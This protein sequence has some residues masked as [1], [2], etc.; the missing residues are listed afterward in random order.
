M[1]IFNYLIASLIIFFVIPTSLFSSNEEIIA[2]L[3][4]SAQEKAGVRLDKSAGDY[5]VS[6]YKILKKE[7]RD[8]LN[9]IDKKKLTDSL[10]SYFSAMRESVPSNILKEE[11]FIDFKWERIT[12]GAV[13]MAIKWDT[14]KFVAIN[15]ITSGGKTLPF[16]AGPVGYVKGNSVII[17]TKEIKA[18]NLTIYGKVQ[19]KPLIWTT[20]GDWVVTTEWEKWPDTGEATHAALLL[21]MPI[22]YGKGCEIHVNSE[23]DTATIY[24]NGRKFYRQT[25]TKTARKPDK[26]KVKIRLENYEDWADE[27]TL[28]K[29]EIWVIKAVLKKKSS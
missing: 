12:I 15:N 11:Y 25:N 9:S 20:T 6:E 7:K 21:P 10:G 18:Y 2:T 5:L 27:R 1:K 4:K 24:F 3:L 13:F 26:W 8:Q 28:K 29:G 19:H 17:S 14:D 22:A 16:S 23:P